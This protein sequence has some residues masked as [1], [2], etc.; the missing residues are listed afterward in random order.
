MLGSWAMASL[1]ARNEVPNGG[2]GFRGE[3]LAVVPGALQRDA[4]VIE[5][6]VRGL[7]GERW[8]CASS[9]NTD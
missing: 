3:E 9:V 5:D 2:D 4:R 8:E 7:G 6:G 1:G